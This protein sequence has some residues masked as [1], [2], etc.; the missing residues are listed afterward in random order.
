[1]NRTILI[2]ASLLPVSNV[3]HGFLAEALQAGWRPVERQFPSADDLR[4]SDNDRRSRGSL[5]QMP[6]SGKQ[7][8]GIV[9]SR[10]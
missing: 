3:D 9:T 7:I 2:A 8:Q 6:S 1:V 4:N 5:P 10:M